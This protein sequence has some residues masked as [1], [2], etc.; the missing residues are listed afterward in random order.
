MK[1]KKSYLH[2]IKINKCKWLKCVLYQIFILSI[3]PESFFCCAN[4]YERVP[5]SRLQSRCCHHRPTWRHIRRPTLR[6]R[7]RR[8]WRQ[9]TRLAS[10]STVPPAFSCR[11]TATSAQRSSS[12]SS[13]WSATLWAFSSSRLFRCVPSR[14]ASTCWRSPS[15]TASTSSG[16]YILSTHITRS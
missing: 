5:A 2:L 3:F 9:R 11:T 13:D 6:T 12:S 7:R 1:S 15:P 14:P 4:M 16:S 8:R 10:C